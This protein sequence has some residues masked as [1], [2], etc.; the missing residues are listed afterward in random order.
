VLLWRSPGRRRG[1]RCSR[2]RRRRQCS[3]SLTDC[4]A[5]QTSSGL[6]A[7]HRQ[8][9]ARSRMSSVNIARLWLRAV[10]AS[11]VERS[12]LPGVRAIFSDNSDRESR[13]RGIHATQGQEPIG[14]VLRSAPAETGQRAPD[15]LSDHSCTHDLLWQLDSGCCGPNSPVAPQAPAAEQR[16]AVSRR[17]D[18]ASVPEWRA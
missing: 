4:R 9:A 18:R 8:K 1:W 7:H 2:R 6:R 11:A 16:W 10:C 17:W 3:S 12:G 13:H 14:T 15:D 5:D